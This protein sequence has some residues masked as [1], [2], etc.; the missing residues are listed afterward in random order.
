MTSTMAEERRVELWHGRDHNGSRSIWGVLLADGRLKIEG[1]DLGAGVAI[2]GEGF[3]EYEW[4]WTVAATDVHRVVEILGGGD[5]GDPLDLLTH[6]ARDAGGRDPG[7]HLKNAG[8]ELG[9]WS[10]VGD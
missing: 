1:Q 9:F 10:R 5:G 7:Q 4:T 3:T 6:W 8:L 2:W